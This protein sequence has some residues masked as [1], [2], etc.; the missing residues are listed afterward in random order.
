MNYFV[1][2]DPDGE[3]LMLARI[4]LPT[5]YESIVPHDTKWTSFPSL[6]KLL[7][8]GDEVPEAKA[9]DIAAS[10]GVMLSPVVPLT[11]PP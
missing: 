10:W 2:R 5:I 9:I 1:Y 8:D 6:V 4:E 7:E 11:T 3:V